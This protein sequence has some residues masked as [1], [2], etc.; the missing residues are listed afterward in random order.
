MKKFQVS[1][2]A[3]VIALTIGL[4]SVAAA[5]ASDPAAAPAKASFQMLAFRT[6]EAG[7]VNLILTK[8]NEKRMWVTLRDAK[9]QIIYQETVE[10][11][12]DRFLKK[13]DLSQLGDGTYRFEVSDGEVVSA[14]EVTLSTAVP[15]RQLALN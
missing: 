6:K 9:G 8:S 2:K 10:K 11:K 4:T 15:T 7:K 5:P 13:F 3:L 14:K 12:S 1:L